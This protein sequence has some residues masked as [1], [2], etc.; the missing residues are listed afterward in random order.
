MRNRVVRRDVFGGRGV[1]SGFWWQC[2]RF[3]S[4][5]ATDEDFIKY[6]L[7]VSRVLLVCLIATVAVASKLSDAWWLPLEQV[8]GK[9][10]FAFNTI[11][12]FTHSA[13]S[14]LSTLVISSLFPLHR[15]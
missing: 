11:P 2:I 4:N 15:S 8:L 12:P 10:D 13:K 1:Q 7:E 9:K 5:N 14:A 6:P 3:S